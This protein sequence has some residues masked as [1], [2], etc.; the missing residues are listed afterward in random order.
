MAIETVSLK[1]AW[2]LLTWL[3]GIFLK[4]VFSKTWFQQQVKIDLRPRYEAVTLYAGDKKEISIW[5]RVSNF[6]YFDIEIDRMEL[7]FQYAGHHAKLIKL[8]R[9]IVSSL[10][11]SDIYLQDN[12]TP[13]H[14]V[15]IENNCNHNTKSSIDGYAEISSKVHNFKLDLLLNDVNQRHVNFNFKQA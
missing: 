2:K 9:Q 8:D 5:L 7:K 14:V 3:P 12:L 15:A 4:K 6:T 1:W 13:D 10:S 11:T